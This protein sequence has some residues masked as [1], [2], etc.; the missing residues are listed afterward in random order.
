M[1]FWSELGGAL[2]PTRQYRQRMAQGDAQTRLMQAQANDAE[3]RALVVPMDI[4]QRML[5]AGP[6]VHDSTIG[7]AVSQTTQTTPDL[8]TSVP[9]SMQAPDTTQLPDA[10]TFDRFL[11]NPQAQANYDA[12]RPTIPTPA[13]VAPQPAAPSAPSSSGDTGL[14][15]R[16][17]AGTGSTMTADRPADPAR[18]MTYKDPHGHSISVELTP[19]YHERLMDMI[20]RSLSTEVDVPNVGKVPM[21]EAQLNT[22]ANKVAPTTYNVQGREQAADTRAGAAIYG[23]DNRLEGVKEGLQTKEKEG[24]LNRDAAGNLLDKKL[25]SQEKVAATRADAQKYAVDS[26]H[27]LGLSSLQIKAAQNAYKNTRDP[28][29]VRKGAEVLL[30]AQQHRNKIAGAL[31]SGVFVDNMGDRHPLQDDAK[32][33]LQ[34]ELDASDRDIAGFRNVAMTGGPAAGGGGGSYQQGR[35]YG[36]MKYLGGDPNSQSSWQQGR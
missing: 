15:G 14:S 27:S 1:G 16:L 31:Q 12:I 17:L 29:S 36:G 3:Q 21:D 20:H 22:Y 6:S 4:K 10:S 33:A 26:R 34:S 24:A 28:G 23:S 8:P 30:K 5:E 2:D 9:S 18:T 19:G 11:G 35:V 25:A 13:P 7:P 32:A